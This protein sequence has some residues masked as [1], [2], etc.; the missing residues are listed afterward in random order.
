[1]LSQDNDR[2]GNKHRTPKGA[3]NQLAKQLYKH[4]TPIG[5]LERRITED[6]LDTYEQSS[7]KLPGGD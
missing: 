2:A 1:M 7:A 6:R 4:S 5:V 3:P